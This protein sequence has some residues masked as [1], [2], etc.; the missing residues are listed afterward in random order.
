MDSPGNNRMAKF[1]PQMAKSRQSELAPEA[2]AM[3]KSNLLTAALAIL[4]TANIFDPL[5][6]LRLKY[7]AFVL[8]G[9]SSFWAIRYFFL[10]SRELTLGLLLF[11]VWPVWSLFY[12][13]V[14]GG[15][16]SVGLTQTTPFI[17]AWLLALILPALDARRPLRAFYFCV[18]LLAIV[19][20]VSF[21]LIVFLPENAISQTIFEYLTSLEG[22]E[23]SFGTQS[24]GGLE[25]PWIYFS[26]TLFLVPAFVYY[27][28]IGKLLRAGA[29][30]LALGLTF[31]KAGL[32]IAC[33][34]GAVYAVSRLF[35]RSDKKA[36]NGIAREGGKGL[37]KLLP[38]VVIAGIPL[39]VFLFLPT[40]SDDIKD[41]WAGNSVT[42]QVRIGHFHSVMEL[43]LEH[44]SYLLVGQGAGVP[45]YS[46]GQSE[47]VQ[48]FEIDY[49]NAIRKFGLPWFIGYSAIVFYSARRLIRTGIREQRAFGFALISGYL[50]AGTNPELLSSLFVTL[51]TLSYFAQRCFPR[52][53]GHQK[54]PARMLNVMSLPS[55]DE[56][57]A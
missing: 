45:F 21:V 55:I 46:L 5:G 12:G 24:F 43:F 18:L 19:V 27:L 56:A 3:F 39:A 23:G 52:R 54:K 16:L 49:L 35:N 17:F 10:T 53:T 57:G 1:C 34:F 48:S 41:S 42:A 9:L 22:K 28:L 13:A 50:A 26:S 8:A 11:V 14:S 37:D 7:L 4:F 40:F 29:L 33:V 38:I 25:V 20:V 47:Y 2:G 15:D 30:L 31:S 6:V 36:T 44:P 32:T 51:M